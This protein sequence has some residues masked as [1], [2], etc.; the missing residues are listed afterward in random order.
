MAYS[1]INKTDVETVEK[2]EEGYDPGRLY[3]SQH[4]THTITSEDWQVKVY[5][6][7]VS[8]HFDKVNID[9]NRLYAVLAIMSFV[10]IAINIIQVLLLPHITNWLWIV[11]FPGVVFLFFIIWAAVIALSNRGAFYT[12]AAD[13]SAGMK[14]AWWHF[15]SLFSVKV[16][17]VRDEDISKRDCQSC[18]IL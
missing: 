1:S 5:T 14:N 13:P 4:V 9:E 7:Y 17:P 12:P 2:E 15:C 6:K 3:Q 8:Y 16:P 10:L 11:L 18:I